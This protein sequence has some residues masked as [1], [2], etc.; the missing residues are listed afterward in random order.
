M[1]A[2]FDTFDMLTW[3]D[4][5]VTLSI[6]EQKWLFVALFIAFAIKVPMIGVHTWLPDAHVQAPTSGSVI[7]AGILLKIGTYAML[8]LIIP[9]LPEATEFFAVYVMG[10]S[11]VAIIYA[12]FLAYKQKDIKKMIAY[13]SIAHMGFIT[14]GL[15]AL[16]EL[17]VQGAVLQMI[18]HGIVS[19]G[20]FFAIGVIYSRLHTRNIDYIG[21]LADKM[22][23]Y[24]VVFMILTLASVGLPGT[25]NFVGEIVILI[26]SFP[27]SATLTLLAVLGILMGA[28]YMLKLYKGMFYKQIDSKKVE[29]VS[30]L[31]LTESLVFLPLVILVF[32]LGLFP[33]LVFDLTEVSV[34]NVLDFFIGGY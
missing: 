11:V 2:Q 33:N 32:V 14:L 8:R 24:A 20:L 25:A 1:Y 9:M 19:A 6:I 29:A 21:N 18:N 7:L 3:A 26:G 27:A 22:P 10:L 12:S 28:C 23:K 5:G 31:T 4:L 13:S 34:L 16:T 15:F 30:D 17:A